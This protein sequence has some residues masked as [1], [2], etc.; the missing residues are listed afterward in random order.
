M[1]AVARK[2]ANLGPSTI[3]VW[4]S[5]FLLYKP[6]H[7]VYTGQ[8]DFIIMATFSGSYLFSEPGP[9][10]Y[11]AIYTEVPPGISSWLFTTT[12]SYFLG[13]ESVT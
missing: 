2:C 4:S 9:A 7:V 3:R 6:P 10:A 5:P 11:N 12:N 1:A 13:H 8:V